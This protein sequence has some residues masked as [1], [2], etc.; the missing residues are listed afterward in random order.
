MP[1][2]RHVALIVDA[3]DP[4]DRKIISGV[5]AYAK[6]V[7]N[8]SLYV[9]TDPLEKL[10]DLRKWQGQGIIANFDDRKVASTV[11]GLDIP[12]VGVGGGYGW[13]DP[14][15]GI[16]YFASDNE[17]IARLAAEHLLDRGFRRLAYYG[18]PRTRINGWSEDRGR[19]FKQRAAEAGIECSVHASRQETARKWRELQRGLI[20][21]LRSLKTPVGLMGCNDA[22][23][24]H[25]LEACRTIGARVPDDVALIGV[26]NDETI[27]DLTSPPLSSVEQGARRMGY[28]AAALLDRLM[29][30]RKI[31]QLRYVVEPEGVVVRRSTDTLAIEDPDLALTVRFIRDRACEGITVYDVVRQLAVS[32]STLENRFKAV[33]G[34]TVHAEIDRVRL[35]RAKELIAGTVLPLKQVAVQSGFNYVQYMTKLFRLRLGQT[36]AEYRNRARQ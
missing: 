4:Y 9:E 2:L 22:G 23:A 29:S 14:A 6:E 30:R 15:T 25:V 24:R 28:E 1:R 34:R 13:Y 31:S 7:G 17:K 32:R 26:D 21:W 5:G 3:A 16:P 11:R 33:M 27:C 36:P 20:A 10:P 12:V 8:W 19:A 18:Y 35:E